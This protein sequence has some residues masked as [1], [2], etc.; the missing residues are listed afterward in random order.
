MTGGAC[1]HG[2]ARPGCPHHSGRDARATKF[3]VIGPSLAGVRDSLLRSLL[4]DMEKGTPK[5]ALGRAGKLCC[6]IGVAALV[7]MGVRPALAQNVQQPGAAKAAQSGVI[8]F[9]P[10]P[11]S[12][13]RLTTKDKYKIYAH[14]NFGPQNFILPAFG[15]AFFMINPPRGYPRD[16]MDGGGAFGRWYGE[17]IAASTAY[18]TGQVLTEVTCHEDPRYVPS[19]SQNLLLRTFHAIGFTLVDK[20]DSGHNT[21]AFS[22]FAGAAAGG[23]SGMALLPAGHNDVMHAGQRALRGLGSVAVRNIVT[24]FRPQ[25]APILRKVRVPSILP[26]WWTRK[27]SDAP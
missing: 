8:A 23:F 11:I 7:L 27:H 9:L 3:A 26:E 14:Q 1:L 4:A 6:E 25:W 16:W 2:N 12:H 5:I 18:R 21:F 17:Q 24:E 13:Q 19:N 22:N 10:P 20:T 15:A